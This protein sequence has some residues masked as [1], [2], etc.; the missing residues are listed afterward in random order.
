[1]GRRIEHMHIEQAC[2]TEVALQK[3]KKKKVFKFSAG[4]LRMGVILW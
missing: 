2:H 1:M 4:L 3:K